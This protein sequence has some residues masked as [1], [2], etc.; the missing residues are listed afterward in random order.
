MLLA[1]ASDWV[2]AFAALAVALLGVGTVVF[3]QGAEQAVLKDRMNTIWDA[4]IKRGV[5][6]LVSRGLGTLKDDDD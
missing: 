1:A 6:S 4:M 3:K 5:A 2:G